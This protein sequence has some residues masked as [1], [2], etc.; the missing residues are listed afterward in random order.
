MQKID[1]DGTYFNPKDVLECGQVFRFKQYKKGYKAFTADKACY[2][3]ADGNKTVIESDYP[4]YFYNY[5]D[6]E[7]EY[8]AVIE[9][10]KKFNIPF[11]TRSCELGKGLR[12]LNQNAEE[13]IFSFIISQNN[14][15]PRIKGIIERICDSLGDKR[16]FMGEEY[17]AFPTAARLAEK[18]ADFY[19]SL[20]AG[21]RDAFIA[22]TA[23][24]I[25]DEGIQNLYGLEAEQLKKQLL[26]YH[27]IGPKVADCV[28][29]F[30]FGKA[31]S[32]PVDTWIEKIYREDF[33][34]TL[35]DRNKIN[36]FFTQTFG[37]YSGLVQQY[38]FYGKRQNL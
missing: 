26:T 4:D 21:Y 11:L 17:R 14:N 23:R 37:Q 32:F 2:V 24:R 35:K 3:Y 12:L 34:G 7:R 33:G 25:A 20:C 38:L 19:K 5:F 6:L 8:A 29:L 22:V 18:D 9:E 15:I 13:T 28:C 36:A 27:G 10:I 16:E 30:G 1:F 31:A